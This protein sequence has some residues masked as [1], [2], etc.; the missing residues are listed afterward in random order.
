MKPK[1]PKSSGGE[2]FAELRQRSRTVSQ[3]Q[4]I[5]WGGRSWPMV[6]RVQ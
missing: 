3:S 2:S 6:A 5:G 1:K 4:L